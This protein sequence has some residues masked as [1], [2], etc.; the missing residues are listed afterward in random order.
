MDTGEQGMDAAVARGS[1]RLTILLFLTVAVPALTVS[2]GFVDGRLA[3][4]LYREPKLI[5][6]TILGW[7]LVSAWLWRFR[8]ELSIAE[9]RRTLGRKPIPVLAVFLGYL[10]TTGTWVRVPQ[11]YWYELNQYLL[12][13]VLLLALLIWSDRDPAVAGT[14]RTGLVVSLAVVTVVG[15]LQAAVPFSF[16]TPIDPQIGTSQPSFMGYKN[17]AALAVLGQIFLV[18]WLVFDGPNTKGR[19]APRLLLGALLAAELVYLSTLGSRTSIMAMMTAALFLVGLWWARKRNLRRTLRALLT[20]GALLL[21]FGLVVAVNKDSRSRAATMAAYLTH[22]A[23]FLDSDRGIYFLNTLNMVKQNP[24]G[25]GLGDWQ[26]HYPI[27][28]SHDPSRYF[29]P[30]I[31]VRRAHSDHVQFLGET[32]WPGLA[33]WGA[34]LLSLIW[35]TA[36]EFF[37]T[38][39]MEPLFLSAQVVAFAAAMTTDYVTEL[40]YN[41]AQ[42]FL[43]VFLAIQTRR[44]I[45]RPPSPE[46]SRTLLVVACTVTALAL[47]Q[48]V[49]HAAL[50][51]R[52]QLAAHLEQSYA[53]A[54]RLPSDPDDDPGSLPF[55][56]PY[57]LGARF[58]SMYG[59]TK[60]FHKDWLILAHCALLLERRDVALAATENALDL[61]PTYPPA[62]LMMSRLEDE[63]ETARRWLLSYEHLLQGPTNGRAD[64]PESGLLTTR[65]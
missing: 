9:V 35:I 19:P 46:N 51:R 47:G 43:V 7:T 17:P 40:P 12:L 57:A 15:L 48:I 13:F 52:V 60:T 26:T 42:F 1:R 22:P 30:E 5:A 23:S 56:R 18:A 59:H 2:W 50:A 41:K 10:A 53:E 27:H 54:L 16:L 49:Y 20:V 28:R 44:P 14:V 11:N 34:F 21:I 24:M 31:Q 55:V 39:R 29:S 4:V 63:P 3:F 45:R 38:G 25:V 58:A 32:G 62:Y 6:I 36:R 37:T 8:T 33:L 61:H 65:P 64:P